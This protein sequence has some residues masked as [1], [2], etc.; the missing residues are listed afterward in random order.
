MSMKPDLPE[1]FAEKVEVSVEGLLLAIIS[2]NT[3]TSFVLPHFFFFLI[4]G[5]IHMSSCVC[6]ILPHLSAAFGEF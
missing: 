6:V 3:A 1:T 2:P 4:Y 5:L